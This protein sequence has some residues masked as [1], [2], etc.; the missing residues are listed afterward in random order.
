MEPPNNSSSA[1]EPELDLVD[2][3]AEERDVDPLFRSA[4]VAGGLCRLDLPAPPEP[5]ASERR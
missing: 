3:E 2:E 4:S 1:G 5:T